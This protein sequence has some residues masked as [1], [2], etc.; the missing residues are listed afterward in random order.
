MSKIIKTGA[1]S[2]ILG[3]F[4]YNNFVKPKEEKLLKITKITKGHDEFKYLD[5][6]REIKNYNKYYSIPDNDYIVLNPSDNFYHDLKELV[7]DH[8][9]KIFTN[10]SLQCFYIDYAGNTDLHDIILE[11][12]QYDFSVFN[13][14]SKINFFVKHILKGIMFLHNKKLCHLDIK[15]ENIMVNKCTNTFKIID[16]G[17]CAQEPFIRFLKNKKGTPG[18]FPKKLAEPEPGL[19]EIKANDFVKVNG[20]I[21]ISKDNML[22]YKIDSYCFGRVL[23]FLFYIFNEYKSVSCFDNNQKRAKIISIISDLCCNDVIKRITITDCYNK[24]F[25]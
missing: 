18:Y 19:P 3:N 2:I 23:N 24:Y 25:N 17:F 22:V 6:V 14:Y 10:T 8:Q 9:I 11:I 20:N 12:K 4:H 7:K 21:P 16:F 5:L 13:S 1:N 15:P